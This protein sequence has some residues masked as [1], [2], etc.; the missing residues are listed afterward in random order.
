M[1]TVMP[2]L[3]AVHDVAGALAF[4]CFALA[5]CGVTRLIFGF[6]WRE[7]LLRLAP[8]PPVEQLRRIHI[9]EW[10]LRSGL[11]WSRELEQGSKHAARQPLSPEARAD[12]QL[13]M[14]T[15]TRGTLWFRAA[16]YLGQCSFCQA[17]WAALLLYV[18]TR[19][20][21]LDAEALAGL[22]PSVLAYAIA[23][24]IV[25]R[26]AAKAVQPAAMPQRQRASGIGGGCAGGNCN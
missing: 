1:S 5:T 4:A 10:S 14:A 12:M 9:I 16:N 7:V 11:I 19:A 23:A 22:I 17:C 6:F 8:K 26:F 25:E 13:E 24:G 15:L 3:S 2:S 20:L 18:G 21:S